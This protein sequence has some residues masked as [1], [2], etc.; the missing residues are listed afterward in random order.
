LIAL[1]KAIQAA[2]GIGL[3]YWEPAWITSDLKDQWGTGSAWENCA[4]FNYDGNAHIGFDFMT[5]DYK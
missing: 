2:D 3:I 5:F 4:F 1:T